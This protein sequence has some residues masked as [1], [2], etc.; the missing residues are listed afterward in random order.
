MNSD[1]HLV[2]SELNLELSGKRLIPDLSIYDSDQ[3]TQVRHLIWIK[4]PPRMAVEII[5]P[6]QTLEEMGARIEQLLAGG[7]RSVW[8]VVPFTKVISIYQKD[9]PLIS[10]VSGLLTDPVTGLSVTVEEIFS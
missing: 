10:A 2:L 4:E 5:S 8:L 3:E 6:S 1:R 7:V 9:A